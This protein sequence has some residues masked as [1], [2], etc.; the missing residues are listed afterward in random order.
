MFAQ[1]AFHSG[2]DIF[3]WLETDSVWVLLLHDVVQILGELT[4]VEFV[5]SCPW[6]CTIERNKIFFIWTCF[7]Q[8]GSVLMTQSSI[9]A[10]RNWS[11]RLLKIKTRKVMSWRVQAAASW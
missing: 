8:A 10:F 1:L 6:Y 7:G 9:R 2:Q 5:L 4:G 11:D 3:I